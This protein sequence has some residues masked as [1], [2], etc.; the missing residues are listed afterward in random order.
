MTEQIIGTKE[1]LDK[2]DITDPCY[3]KDVWCRINNFP[4][5]AGTY[6][7]YVRM[8]DN[9]ETGGWGERVARIGIRKDKADRY[10][11]KGSIGVDAGLAGFFNN[12]PD[13]TDEQRSEFVYRDGN[14]W[15]IEDG[16]YSTSGYGDGAYD[17]Y[18][19]RKEK[20]IVE[21]YIDFIGKEDLYEDEEE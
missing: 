6:E 21:V 5:S 19:G 4:I 9:E 10:V 14:A 7:C 13:Y 20:D 18:I 15:I 3:N 1:F 11:R 16:F 2:I 12:K 17:V 8:A